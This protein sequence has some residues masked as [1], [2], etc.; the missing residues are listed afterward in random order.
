MFCDAVYGPMLNAL[1]VRRRGSPA[2]L[3]MCLCIWRAL[4][5]AISAGN[6]GDYFLHCGG[7]VGRDFTVEMARVWTWVGAGVIAATSLS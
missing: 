2:R 3:G 6:T 4:I 1:E 7:L 5:P